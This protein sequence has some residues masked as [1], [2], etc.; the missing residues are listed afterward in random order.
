ME[1]VFILTPD[2]MI[3]FHSKQI[4]LNETRDQ[5]RDT[6]VKVS[7][8]SK[9]YHFVWKNLALLKYIYIY[10]LLVL[11]SNCNYRL[12]TSKKEFYS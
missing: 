8:L 2:L 5:L 6:N 1:T 3:F 4:V 7:N 9:L 11:L 12:W 10:I